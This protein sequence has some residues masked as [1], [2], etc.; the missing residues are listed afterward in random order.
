MACLEMLL[1]AGANPN[2]DETQYYLNHIGMFVQHVDANP[3]HSIIRGCF[4][5]A[6]NGVFLSLGDML[7]YSD[8]SRRLGQH[9]LELLGQTCELCCSTAAIQTIL[10]LW[11][12]PRCMI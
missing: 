8:S 6:L 7:Q 10:M 11:G 12:L 9:V 1:Q 4:S 2:F 5:S 3:N